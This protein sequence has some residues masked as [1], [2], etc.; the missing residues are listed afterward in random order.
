MAAD[1]ALEVLK[2]GP[3]TLIQD[4]GRLGFGS[5]GVGSSG[6]AD[7]GAFRLGARLLAQPYSAAALE[8]TFG[9]L[10][11]RARG[12]LQLALTGAQAPAT[13]DGRAVGYFGPFTVADGQVLT[14]AS[15]SV[16]LRSYLSVRG[17]IA[18]APVLGS[19][20][21]DTLSGLGPPPLR[22]GDV[23][24]VGP[25]PTA[26]PNLDLAPAPVISAETLV[27]QALRGPRDDW[28][29]DLEA[30]AAT[31]W[32]ISTDSDRVGIRLSGAP[33][34]RRASR[35]GH[36]LPSEGVVSGSVQVPP[37]GQPVVFLADHPVTGG[38][39]VVAVLLDADI[40]RAAQ[41][42]PGPQLRIIVK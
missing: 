41:A 35:L 18:V 37:S 6:A 15:P 34:K 27:L 38:Y 21:T 28:L 36:E 7:R 10:S 22:A 29:A 2:A 11:V 32:T 12:D 4:L 25:A 42:V 23:L 8:V 26:F 1:R 33:L 20:S 30:L 13:L 39:P 5:I 24:P 16:G 40:D 19:R 31:S 3:L 14:L 17:G 9:G